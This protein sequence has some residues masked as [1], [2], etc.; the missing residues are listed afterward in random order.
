MDPIAAI[1]EY[2]DPTQV[3]VGTRD[4]LVTP[5]PYYGEAYMAYHDGDEE[6]VVLDGDHIFDVL[7]GNGPGVLDAAIAESLDWFQKTLRP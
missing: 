5:Q 3:V 2:D 7:S 4:D 6:L 1:T